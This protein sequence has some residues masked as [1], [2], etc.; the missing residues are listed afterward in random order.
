M[1]ASAS[2]LFVYSPLA[3]AGVLVASTTSAPTPVPAAPPSLKPVPSCIFLPLRLS[4]FLFSF[5][6]SSALIDFKIEVNE[7][8]S[9]ALAFTSCW[10]AEACAKVSA[11]ANLLVASFIIDCCL[12]LF[13]ILSNWDF[14]SP[15]FCNNKDLSASCCVFSVTCAFSLVCGFFFSSTASA[16]FSFVFSVFFSTGLTSIAV[17]T[18][19]FD[20]L[21]EL[22]TLLLPL[23]WAELSLASAA[24]APKNKPIPI[25]TLAAPAFNFLIE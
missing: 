24:P 18:G 4:V 15:I 12:E 7:L 14:S 3:T 5:T 10:V 21:E 16:T 19:V 9:L 25:R 20:S 23:V 17:A 2:S 11:V 13:L 8:I 1:N 22:S 6:V